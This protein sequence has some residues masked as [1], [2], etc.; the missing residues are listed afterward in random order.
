VKTEYYLDEL[1]ARF[2]ALAR[3]ATLSDQGGVFAPVVIAR[4][5]AF[6]LDAEVAMASAGPI[7]AVGRWPHNRG[8]LIWTAPINFP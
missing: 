8:S 3:R 7:T 6:Q 2:A 5:Q 1:I 4:R